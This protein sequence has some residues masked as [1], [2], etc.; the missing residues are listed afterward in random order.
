MAEQKPRREPTVIDDN[1]LRL[2][3]A[4]LRQ[5]GRSSML[6]VKMIENNPG[7]EVDL[8]FKTEPKNGKEGYPIKIETPMAPVPFRQLMNLVVRV[9]QN[10]GACE[11]E[12]D[13]WGHPFLW[14]AEQ[15]K[16]VRSKERMIISRFQIAK[17]EDGVVTLGVT[18]KGRDDVIFEFKEDEFHM[19][20]QGGQPA[21]VSITSPQAAIAWAETM[22]D[23][24]FAFFADKWKEPEYQKAKRLERAQKFGD[25]PSYGNQQQSRPQQQA[26]APAAAP[27]DA[28]MFDEDIP[29]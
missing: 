3:G 1:K 8:G 22:I 13:N 21:S 6:R 16:N 29:F 19:T 27:S 12:K 2:W 10:K 23:V 26:A 7:I 9:A 4:K 25:K 20:M 14:D 17:R 24:Y 28:D 5:D 18:A 15:R 11:F